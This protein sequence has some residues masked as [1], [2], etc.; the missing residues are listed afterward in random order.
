MNAKYF[1]AVTTAALA[2]GFFWASGCSSS[3]SGDT[4][5][6]GGETCPCTAGGTCDKGLSC[7]SNRCV[8][9]ADG[10]AGTTTTA[11]AGGGSAGSSSTTSPTT[12]GSSGSA[13]TT[14]TGGAGGGS[15]S[16]ALGSTCNATSNCQ[17]G[18]VCMTPT[19]DLATGAGSPSGICTV[20]CTSAPATA[21][22]PFAG[23][24]VGFEVGGKA[25]CM[26]NCMAG[27]AATAL[28]MKC[29]LRQDT[30][31]A[32]LNMGSACVPICTDDAECGTR[33][34]NPGSGLCEATKMA[35]APLGASCMVDADC[36]GFF[37]LPFTAGDGGP[38]PGACSEF[39][40]FGNTM[41]GCSFRINALDAGPPVGACL[42]TSS[43]GNIGDLGACGQ[44]CDVPGDCLATFPLYTCVQDP[45]IK[46]IFGHGYCG[47][48]A[49]AGP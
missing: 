47:F 40:R 27:V 8:R 6:V 15:G 10:G 20:E 14:G 11:G 26:E 30:A 38:A 24:C 18:L 28:N 39:C 1:V 23:T 7:F 42:Y 25:F 17:A 19:D 21:C 43:I 16:G 46:R 35:G 49:D 36:A 45:T 33:K 2:I 48:S 13:G 29:H 9:T 31:C 41:S 5:A 4:C 12:T 44:L 37:C 22:A 32:T 3:S 34:C